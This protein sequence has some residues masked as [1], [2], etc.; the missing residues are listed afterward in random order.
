M[1]RQPRTGLQVSSVQAMP[2]SQSTVSPV[3]APAEQWSLLVQA[4]LSL[5]LLLS[6]L[7]YS[8][9]L[10]GSQLSSVQGLPSLQVSDVPDT[11]NPPLQVSLPLHTSLSL[12]S[13]SMVHCWQPVSEASKVVSQSLSW[14][15]LQVAWPYGPSV[16][17][18]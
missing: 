3:Q 6:S 1:L 13:S 7:V 10:V 4:S 8:H 16:L 5:Q 15:S 12:Q 17:P 14:L 11:Q 18:G 9:P 2:S